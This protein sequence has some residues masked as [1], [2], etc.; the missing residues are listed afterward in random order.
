M[1]IQRVDVVVVAA[2]EEPSRRVRDS[3]LDLTARVE[4]PED[5]AG[6]AAERPDVAVPVADEDPPLRDERRSLAGAD[7]ALPAD[8]PRASI[9]GDDEPVQAR[10]RPVARPARQEDLDHEL[11][12]DPRRRG[13]AAA[14]LPAP[15][16][17]AGLCP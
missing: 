4:A 5:G 12:R 11:A 10:S 2:E 13:R 1:R 15:R 9:E 6:V 3:A 16:A 7:H 17:T 8:L 14:G